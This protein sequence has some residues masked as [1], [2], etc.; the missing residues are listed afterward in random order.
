MGATGRCTRT[1]ACD[2]CSWPEGCSWPSCS[3]QGAARVRKGKSPRLGQG[4]SWLCRL[5]GCSE[6][7]AHSGRKWWCRKVRRG[8]PCGAE[9]TAWREA[10]PVRCIGGHA[11]CMHE[12][13]APPQPHVDLSCCCVWLLRGCWWPARWPCVGVVWERA[14][15]RCMARRVASGD[16]HECRGPAHPSSQGWPVCRVIPCRVRGTTAACGGGRCL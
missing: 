8:A 1:R 9:H 7:L 12:V 4:R 16:A 5:Q 2:G 15:G 3:R 11:S 14:G 10:P 13:D 6:P